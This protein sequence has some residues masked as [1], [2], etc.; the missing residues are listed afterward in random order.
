MDPENLGAIAIIAGIVVGVLIREALKNQDPVIH[1]GAIVAAAIMTGLIAAVE[2]GMV[3]V[4]LV[5]GLVGGYLLSGVNNSSMM[6]ARR[7]AR[8]KNNRA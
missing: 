8:A 7:E 2:G 6:Q 5:A 4:P 3:T 1:E